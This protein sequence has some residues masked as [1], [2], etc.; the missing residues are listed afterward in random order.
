[1]GGGVGGGGHISPFS[2]MSIPAVSCLCHPP[3]L[4]SCPERW[5]RLPRSRR[6]ERIG[7]F[8]EVVCCAS[9]LHDA[10]LPGSGC[11]DRPAGRMVGLGL[12][13]YRESLRLSTSSPSPHSF[14]SG[15]LDPSR[16]ECFLTSEQPRSSKPCSSNW[17]RRLKLAS[18][19]R[20]PTRRCRPLNPLTQ[21]VNTGQIILAL[22][23]YAARTTRP[24]RTRQKNSK[25]SKFNLQ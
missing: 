18:S 17:R 24:Q 23:R 15:Y 21:V 8:P 12:H 4:A 10:G 6:Q 3:V 19:A 14:C 13:I 22:S 25:H 20:R 2:R 7:R 16:P 9:R 11:A 1:M 5:R